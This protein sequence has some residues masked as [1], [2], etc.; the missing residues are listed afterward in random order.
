M[1]GSECV[2]KDMQRL[3]VP[4]WRTLVWGKKDGRNWLRR[5]ELCIKSCR[6]VTGRRETC[7]AFGIICGF[8]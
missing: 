5:P 6:A 8:M 3:K 1:A 4:F 2:K 7:I